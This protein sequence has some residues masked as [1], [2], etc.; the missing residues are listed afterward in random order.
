MFR[1]LCSLVAVATLLAAHPFAQG[2]TPR[3][4]TTTV[5]AAKP[6]GPVNLNSAT[7]EDLA[8]LPGIGEKTAAKILEYREKN[9]PFKKVEE[10]M[11]VQ[12]IGEKS[13]LKLKPQ[14][15]V[16]AAASGNTQPK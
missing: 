3:T 6:T 7:L 2:A 15:T 14:L 8:T 13:F 5:V 4:R 11:N 16:A 9:G 12:G 1:T 10:L